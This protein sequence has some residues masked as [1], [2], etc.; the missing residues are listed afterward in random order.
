MHT[1]IP[2]HSLRRPLGE[3]ETTPVRESVVP[4]TLRITNTVIFHWIG[5]GMEMQRM[6]E[7]RI[8]VETWLL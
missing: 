4:F 7:I 5:Y 2:T 8:Q 1:H 6:D 3:A